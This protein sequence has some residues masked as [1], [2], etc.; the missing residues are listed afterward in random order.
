M[1]DLE[2]AE[3]LSEP[4]PREEAIQ[5]LEKL[6]FDVSGLMHNPAA[7]GAAIGAA[8]MFG[9]QAAS[10]MKGKSGF[11]SEQRYFGRRADDIERDIKAKEESGQPLSYSDRVK[12]V[13]GPAYKSMADVAADFPVRSAF[14][15]GLK[16]AVAG[17]SLGRMLKSAQAPAAPKPAM[18]AV[19][20]PVVPALPPPAA[21]NMKSKLS[22]AD[23]WGRMLAKEAF[24]G[25]LMAGQAM[26]GVMRSRWGGAG[27]GAAVGAAR[28]ATSNDP[29][30]SLVGSIGG[31]AMLGGMAHM[32][33]KSGIGAVSKMNNQVGH[34]ARDSGRM[35]GQAK[36][37]LAPEAI[38]GTA[39]GAAG[40]PKAPKGAPSA[41]PAKVAPP[42][43]APAG[44]PTGA[45]VAATAP[46]AASMAAPAPAPQRTTPPIP[47]IG[48]DVSVPPSVGAP[49]S[50]NATMRPIPLK[51]VVQPSNQ[52]PA[53]SLAGQKMLP[54]KGGTTGA[55]KQAAAH[56]RALKKQASRTGIWGPLK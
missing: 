19:A 9:L 7:V 45:P 49:I 17:A 50:S 46:G 18:P 6:G 24:A 21:P 20:A 40:A 31:G 29:N 36:K 11:S 32:G 33:M 54:A 44:A 25:N 27:V 30:K 2:L 16:G 8:T 53:S 55:T 42:A 37:G 38:K 23:A 12:K 15:M 26:R 43:A 1:T 47:V 22:M 34:F 10:N 13:T 56:M 39:M 35:A 28:Y 48:R 52:M 5:V 51:N 4:L 3:A 41:T 14:S